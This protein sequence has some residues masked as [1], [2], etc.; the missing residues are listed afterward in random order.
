VRELRLNESSPQSL[1]GLELGIDALAPIERAKLSILPGPAE[2]WARAASSCD[3]LI[4]DPPRKGLDRALRDHLR[5]EPPARLIYVSCGLDSFLADARRLLEGGKLRLA[6]LA[7][8]DLFPYTDH[9]ETVA[10]FERV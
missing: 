1:L 2:G 6:S 9:A 7:A 3:V 5:E 10:R 4:V 8:F